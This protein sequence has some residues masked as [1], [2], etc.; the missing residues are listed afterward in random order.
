MDN[1]WQVLENILKLLQSKSYGVGKA[2]LD[3][4]GSRCWTEGK[5]L[6]QNDVIFW[7]KKSNWSYLWF[8]Y[9]EFSKGKWQ[10]KLF[11]KYQW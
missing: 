8:L 6:L 11:F 5:D 1:A 2:W 4:K 7:D 3:Q 9:R 10:I